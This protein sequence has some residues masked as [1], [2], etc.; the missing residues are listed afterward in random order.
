MSERVLVCEDDSAIR[1]LIDKLLTRHGLRVECV[2]SGAEAMARLRR[3]S[4]D[5]IVLDLLMPDLSG[6]EV[7]EALRRER[8]MLLERVIV[9]TAFSQAFHVPLPVGAVLRKPFDLREFDDIVEQMLR[10]TDM[11]GSD[12]PRA[13]VS[14]EIR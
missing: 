12:R 3:F 6:Y 14:G 11:H 13:R 1:L 2:G 7:I 5:V 10:R 9:V 8:P 4:Y